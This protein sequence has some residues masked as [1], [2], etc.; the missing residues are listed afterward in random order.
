MAD[1]IKRFSSRVENYIK[2]R[3]GYPGEI[4][5]L[6]AS[7]CALTPESVIADIG[8]GT[9]IL[10][11]LFLQHG[12]RVYGVEPNRE[13]HAAAEQYLKGYAYFTSIDGK[14]EAT[15]LADDSVDF[16]IAGQAFHWFDQEK[17]RREFVRI[18]KPEGWVIL[19]WNERR[20]SSTP[21]LR[22]YEELFLKYGTDYEQ[23]RHENVYEDIASFFAP[24][25]FRAAT[26][27]NFQ[28]LDFDGLQGRAVSASYTPEPGHSNYGPM[29]EEL[30]QI[31]QSHQEDGKVTIEYDTKIYY[32]H[33]RAID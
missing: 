16:V 7:Q 5:N 9:G 8:S 22:A 25:G 27:D 10:S 17:A 1:S 24:G 26:F 2:Y 31:F 15:M 19:I 4:I 11:E 12:N 21:F 20:L 33:L 23:V 18:L 3:P 28:T 6:L 29:L 32:G 30:V 14:A 13:M